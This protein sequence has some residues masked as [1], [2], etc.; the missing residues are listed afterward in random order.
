M[1]WVVKKYYVLEK[2]VEADTRK[3]AMDRF[4]EFDGEFDCI[5]ITAKR[6]KG[7]LRK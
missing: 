5:K 7:V 3:Q 4:G 6:F 2:T 1:K